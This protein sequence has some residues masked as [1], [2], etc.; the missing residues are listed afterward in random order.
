M[1]DLAEHLE[2]LDHCLTAPELAR[3]LKLHRITVYRLAA[4]GE[5][6]SFKIATA[7]RFDPRAVAKWIRAQAVSR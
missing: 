5:I 2:Q 1:P 6:P 4:E 7:V 3:L